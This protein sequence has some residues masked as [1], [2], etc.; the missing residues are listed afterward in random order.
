[1]SLL[2]LIQILFYDFEATNLTN[3]RDRKHNLVIT[4]SVLFEP[5]QGMPYIAGGITDGLTTDI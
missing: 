2:F 4:P 5:F 1:M 3:V